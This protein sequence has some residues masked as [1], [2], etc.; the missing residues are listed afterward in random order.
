M[1]TYPVIL[2]GGSGTRL[3]P[4]STD[5][6]PKQFHSILGRLSLFQETALRVADKFVYEKPIIVCNEN[7]RFLVEQQLLQINVSPECIIL[8]P[9]GKNTSPSISA[10]AIYLR[11]NYSRDECSVLILAADHYIKDLVA[12]NEAFR[13]SLKAVEAKLLVT[14]GILPTA[15]ET[16]Y[17]YIRVGNFSVEKNCYEV[18]NF[19]EKPNS[20]KALR[21][22]NE[23]NYF[24]NSGIFH[25]N[26][27]TLLDVLLSNDSVNFTHVEKSLFESKR[28][29]EFI[30]LS[31]KY[32]INCSDIS[33][34]YSV[35]EKLKN[36]G[37]IK[38]D[39]GW[40]DL[41]S[42][43]SIWNISEKDDLGNSGVIN[44]IFID[45]ENNFIKTD[46]K[47]KRVALIGVNNIV[48]IDSDNGLLICNKSSTQKVKDIKKH[49]E[50][51]KTTEHSKAIVHRPWGSYRSVDRGLRHQVK[52]IIVN[53]GES[54]SLQMHHHRAEHWIVVSGTA[55]VTKDKEV[56]ILSENE[57]IYIP[58]G[59]IHSLKNPGVIP[60]EIVEVQSGSYL[61]ED[62]IV[63][64]SDKYG[65]VE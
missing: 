39:G 12:F 3:W 33:F 6:F 9:K 54:L 42:W 20:E 18:Q 30:R 60:L 43:E 55:E 49:F 38:F 64:F 45:S 36:V 23:G 16:G 57:S 28:E 13:A 25:I 7:H 50:N 11:D 51:K 41:G 56:L 63:R 19:V 59:H 2:A 29:R 22:L 40:T 44:S 21:Y 10:A 5:E 65:R 48:V 15:P 17:G 52:R 35:V 27:E 24:W 58:L 4:M 32:F 8:E 1:K 61:G 47:D 34:D 62:D 37:M 14:F 46:E 31:K 53:P 26:L